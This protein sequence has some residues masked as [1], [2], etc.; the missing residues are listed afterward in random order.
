MSEP[1]Y[2]QNLRAE[3]RRLNAEVIDLNMA[4]RSI[5]AAAGGTVRIPERLIVDPPPTIERWRYEGTFETVVR[6]GPPS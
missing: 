1:E 2:V 5:V 6:V 3:V 4:I